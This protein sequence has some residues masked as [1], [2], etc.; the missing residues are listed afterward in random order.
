LI[1]SGDEWLA[2]CAM[3]TA[4]QLGLKGLARDIH[5]ICE[6]NDG[7]LGQVARDAAVALA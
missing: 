5:G 7:D 1:N 2:S 6:R 4:A 3:A